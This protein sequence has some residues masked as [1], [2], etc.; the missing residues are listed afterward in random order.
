[1]AWS[2]GGTAPVAPWLHTA[3]ARTRW[4]ASC[5]PPR[6]CINGWTRTSDPILVEEPSPR[7]DWTWRGWPPIPG[8][9]ATPAEYGGWQTCRFCQVPAHR[10]SRSARLRRT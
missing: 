8:V 7:P 4:P 10:S 2:A 3:E 1:M 9:L 5:S 6:R